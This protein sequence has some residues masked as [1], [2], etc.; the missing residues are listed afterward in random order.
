[1]NAERLPT[2]PHCFVCG[3]ENKRGLSL[4]FEKKGDKVSALFTSKPWMVGFKDVIHGGILSTLL[5]EAV[6]W[7]AY[8]ATGRFGVTAELSVR[9]RKPFLS[10]EQCL[11]EGWT[12]SSRGR[13]W[14]A[15]AQAVQELKGLMASAKAKIMPFPEDK[16]NEFSKCLKFD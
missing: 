3:R 7:A 11:I 15:E 2:Y 13:I 16:Q 1:M 10:G 4:T 9:F 8:T 6:I 14:T 5:D 12:V